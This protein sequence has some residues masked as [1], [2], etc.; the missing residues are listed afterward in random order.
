MDNSCTEQGMR[1]GFESAESRTN[2]RLLAF[3]FVT[4]M[5]K[6][7]S[8]V[9]RKADSLRR[10]AAIRV[11]GTAPEK[12]SSIHYS[13][14]ESTGHSSTQ[15]CGHELED[16]LASSLWSLLED[17]FQLTAD[18]SAEQISLA[19]PALCCRWGPHDWQHIERLNL[20]AMLRTVRDDPVSTPIAK[21]V[22]PALCLA[23]T[24]A[25]RPGSNPELYEQTV[26]AELAT[27]NYRSGSFATVALC[28]PPSAA[29]RWSAAATVKTAYL[30]N[31]LSGFC[32]ASV[33]DCPPV[34]D[35]TP[36]SQRFTQRAPW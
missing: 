21:E 27:A 35:A 31:A 7:A 15:G 20:P 34:D 19:L 33:P 4:V 29:A 14:T 6:E 11:L 12:P 10:I 17:G 13:P 8:V 3:D 25:I 18:A 32:G 5:L 24:L 1:H 9:G 22:A 16:K 23:T 30:D 36:R 2:E 26:M 28:L